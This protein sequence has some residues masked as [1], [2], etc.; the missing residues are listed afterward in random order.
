[1]L[2]ILV[3][4]IFLLFVIAQ[5]ESTVGIHIFPPFWSSICKIDSQWE[6]AVW[7]RKLKQGLCINLEGWDGVGDGREVHKGEDVYAYGWF[8]LRFYR[9][10]Q[11]SVK[12]LSFNKK[13]IKKK[14]LFLGLSPRYT[15]LELQRREITNLSLEKWLQ[16]TLLQVVNG[17]AFENH[18]VLVSHSLPGLKKMSTE[19]WTWICGTNTWIVC[20]PYILVIILIG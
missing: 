18:W 10:Q 3:Y 17:S 7:L 19:G 9:K 16:V 4:R 15:E 12:Q 6:F 8:M 2:T 11:N 1:M 5:Y 14:L 20:L 13:K